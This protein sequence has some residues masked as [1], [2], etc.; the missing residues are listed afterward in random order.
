[1]AEN[2]RPFYYYSDNTKKDDY[3]KEYVKLGDENMTVSNA[4]VKNYD[5]A[6]YVENVPFEIECTVS[7]P[8]VERSGDKLM[9]KV[10]DVIGRQAELYQEKKRIND[11]DVHYPHQ[12]IRKIQVNIPKGYRVANLS[13]AEIKFSFKDDSGK[14]LMRFV[15]AA[16]EKDGVITIDIDEHYAFTQL[17]KSRFEDFKK[18]INA[19]ADFNKVILIFEPVK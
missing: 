7:K 3:I 6:N 18:V 17:S 10:G 19:A 2:V 15:S 1:M 12:Y 8:M 11:I 4:K 5:Y 16:S 9:L 14:D 13:S